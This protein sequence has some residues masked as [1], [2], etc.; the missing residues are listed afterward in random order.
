MAKAASDGLIPKYAVPDKYVILD[1]IPKTSVGKMDKKAIRKRYAD[2]NLSP[3]GEQ[4]VKRSE[5]QM[6]R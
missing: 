1:E 3:T 5:E 6:R 2:G 4:G